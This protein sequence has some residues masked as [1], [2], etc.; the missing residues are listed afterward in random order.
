MIYAAP[1]LEGWAKTFVGNGTLA[2]FHIPPPVGQVHV[3]AKKGF[4]PVNTVPERSS[5][6]SL[7][8][9]RNSES[10]SEEEGYQEEEEEEEDI[11]GEPM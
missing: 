7:S 10:E 3:Q 5:L 8:Y 1:T 4:A 11:D 2:S 9:S 6:L